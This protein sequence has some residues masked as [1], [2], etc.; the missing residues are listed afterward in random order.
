MT[1]TPPVTADELRDERL[2]AREAGLTVDEWRAARIA[3]A[4][5]GP[6]HRPAPARPAPVK[7]L[8]P[9]YIELGRRELA[10]IRAILA[11]RKAPRP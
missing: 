9:H 11:D 4:A 3:E 8:E 10:R 2:A 5:A 6:V 7:P 1:Y